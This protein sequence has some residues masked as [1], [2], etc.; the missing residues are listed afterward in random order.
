MDKEKLLQIRISGVGDPS[1]G[2]VHGEY[3]PFRCDNCSWWD[4]NEDACDNPRV[5]SNTSLTERTKDNRVK[6]DDDDCCNHFFTKGLDLTEY[7]KD[8]KLDTRSPHGFPPMAGRLG[9]YISKD[10]KSKGK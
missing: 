7:A 2:F 10:K 5:N 9:L 6:A 8:M 1:D 3:G 4:E